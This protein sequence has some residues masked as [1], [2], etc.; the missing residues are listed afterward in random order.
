MS[1]ADQNQPNDDDV[2]AVS[3]S[4]RPPTGAR[5]R[6]KMPTPTV[7]RMTRA[8]DEADQNFDDDGDDDY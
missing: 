2:R 7:A 5:T 1:D 6:T 3:L 8:D 4:L